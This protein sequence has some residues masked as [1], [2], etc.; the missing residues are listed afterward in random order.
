MPQR[1]QPTN[2]IP[3]KVQNRIGGGGLE[4]EHDS[5]YIRLTQTLARD[6]ILLPPTIKNIHIKGFTPDP[7]KKTK[8]KEPTSAL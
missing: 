6:Y 7:E 8:K 3:A 5:G 4:S 2:L 1:Q